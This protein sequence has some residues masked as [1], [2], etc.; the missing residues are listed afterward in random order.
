MRG[1][2][3]NDPE[4]LAVI[5]RNYASNKIGDELVSE[6]VGVRPVFHFNGV[7]LD[8]RSTYPYASLPNI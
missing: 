3:I 4:L 8:I 7:A 2:V 6:L 1:S 5:A